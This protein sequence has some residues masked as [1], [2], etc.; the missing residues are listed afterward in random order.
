MISE[1][2]SSFINR[3]SEVVI[4]V[5][6]IN[7]GVYCV[8]IKGS[9]YLFQTYE[10]L[11]EC[12]FEMLE[13]GF[14]LISNTSPVIERMIEQWEKQLFITDINTIKRIQFWFEEQ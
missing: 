6:K 13:N 10:G 1:F 3:Q 14:H 9:D 11:Y 8:D 2:V 7:N 4:F 12:I 5:Q